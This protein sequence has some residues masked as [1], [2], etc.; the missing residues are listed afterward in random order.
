MGASTIAMA[1]AL[2]TTSLFSSRKAASTVSA[3]GGVIAFILW[4]VLYKVPEESGF[5]KDH[6]GEPGVIDGLKVVVKNKNI[7]IIAVCM[8]AIMG[9]NVVIG[10]FAPTALQ[11]RGIDAVAAGTYSAVYTIGC[12]LSCFI[13]PIVAEKLRSVKKTVILFAILAFFGTGFSVSYAPAGILL[14]AAMLL[15]GIFVGGSIPLLCG[16][17]VQLKGIGPLYAGT[18]GGFISTIELIGA[19]VIPGY[20]LVPISAGNYNILFLAGGIC[21]LICAAI[22]ILLPRTE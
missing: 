8:M 10:S 12:F 21:M 19:V 6:A 11:E 4:I 18:A 7:Y 17:P 5:E 16:L 13:A 22:A 2:A 15:T 9:A 14:G 20:I 1:V 3:I